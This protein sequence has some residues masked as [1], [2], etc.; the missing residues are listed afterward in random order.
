VPTPDD[1]TAC[2]KVAFRIFI[3]NF[4]GSDNIASAMINQV[5]PKNRAIS[6]ITP[7]ASTDNNKNLPELS[8]MLSE[9]SSPET[10]AALTSKDIVNAHIITGYGR[11]ALA[12]AVAR[13]AT[14]S[15]NDQS[16]KLR[17]QRSSEDGLAPIPPTPA[18][19]SRKINQVHQVSTATELR[20]NSEPA[21][22]SQTAHTPSVSA[23]RTL[24]YGAMDVDEP[25]TIS[26]VSSDGSVERYQPIFQPDQ[27]DT[28]SSQ[29]TS[30]PS[31]EPRPHLG[32]N[33]T[34]NA[35]KTRSTR[36][37]VSELI[38]ET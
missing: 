22:T 12:V 3:L 34:H 32:P 24:D 30:T 31:A 18:A 2:T 33:S 10:P 20:Q 35:S 8:I 14:R 6:A 37:K 7:K 23:R 16:R 27:L 9:T 26:L 15:K 1:I 17:L 28:S 19:N 5:F 25:M 21:T 38:L 4:T 29:R 13:D 36:A 11:A